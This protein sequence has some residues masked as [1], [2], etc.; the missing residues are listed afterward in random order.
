MT[1]HH[2]HPHGA[3]VPEEEDELRLPPE[4]KGRLTKFVLR[5]QQQQA[6]T[7]ISDDK[8]DKHQEQ[9]HQQLEQKIQSLEQKCS[10]LEAQAILVSVQQLDLLARGMAWV[11]SLSVLGLY[12]YLT[13]RFTSVVYHLL[14]D[15]DDNGDNHWSLVHALWFSL[16]QGLL[17]G[18]LWFVPYWYN[19]T[20]HGALHRRFE[21]FAIAFLV[22]ARVRLCR[23]RERMFILV[24]NDE[25]S[26]TNQD[27]KQSIDD[28]DD[29]RGRRRWA[30][31]ASSIFEQQQQQPS[32]RSRSGRAGVNCPKGNAARRAPL[33]GAHCIIKT[34]HLY[35]HQ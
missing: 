35:I 5:L 25:T 19:E 9:R 34:R 15:Y 12:L 13:G 4:L 23:W 1:D 24:D 16:T 29:D 33:Q 30:V 27:K 31:V 6:S 26:D 17:R 22:I 20:T 21:V 3:F 32:A 28:D 14:D 18:A 11:C 10:A 7:N 8:R 2:R